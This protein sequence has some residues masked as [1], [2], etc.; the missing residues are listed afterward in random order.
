MLLLTPTPLITVKLGGFNPSASEIQLTFKNLTHPVI[1]TLR[2]GSFQV[3]WEI[4]THKSKNQCMQIRIGSSFTGEVDHYE[5]KLFG[6]LLE[7][8]SSELLVLWN[9]MKTITKTHRFKNPSGCEES[10]LLVLGI[11]VNPVTERLVLGHFFFCF[12]SLIWN[13]YFQSLQTPGV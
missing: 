2:S 12:S 10:C 11:K 1:Q 3:A 6:D 13:P 8:S 4:T 7:F 9:C 5:K